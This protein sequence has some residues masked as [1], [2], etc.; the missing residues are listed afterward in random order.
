MHAATNRTVSSDLQY[1]PRVPAILDN[2]IT[3]NGSWV[4]VQDMSRVSEKYGR[5]IN[6][7]SLAFPH[8]GIVAAARHPLNRILQPDELF[9]SILTKFARFHA[10][11]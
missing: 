1:R 4:N 7:V 3:V 11:S 8:P 5:I 10:R 9:V 6:N 2:N